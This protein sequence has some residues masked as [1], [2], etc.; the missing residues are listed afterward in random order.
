LQ[1]W[2]NNVLADL[3]PTYDE[4]IFLKKTNLGCRETFLFS[5]SRIEKS[6]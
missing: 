4:G 5:I 1:E 2:I 3:L 6:G